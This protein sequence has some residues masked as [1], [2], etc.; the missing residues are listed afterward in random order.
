MKTAIIGW[1]TLRSSHPEVFLKKGA[2]EI[3]SKFTGEHLCRSVISIK[4]LCN[5][6]EVTLRDDGFSPANLQHIFRTPFSKTPLK[7]CFCTLPLVIVEYH[8]Y[9]I[10]WVSSCLVNFLWCDGEG[11]QARFWN[12]LFFYFEQV[13]EYQVY[14]FLVDCGHF[15]LSGTNGILK[16]Y[17]IARSDQSLKWNHLQWNYFIERNIWFCKKKFLFSI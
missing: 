12:D 15:E 6:I 3:Y 2:L 9:I 16:P 17:H 1:Y 8:K 4:L 5:F 7:A 13:H 14:T 11:Y 10:F